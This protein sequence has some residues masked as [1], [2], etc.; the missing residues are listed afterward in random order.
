MAAARVRQH[1]RAKTSILIPEEKALNLI[2]VHVSPDPP[3][4]A[5]L[6]T[7]ENG[8]GGG[9]EALRGRRDVIPGMHGETDRLCPA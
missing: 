7:L 5:D 9:L 2:L 1:W 3:N 4:P 6:E 8:A